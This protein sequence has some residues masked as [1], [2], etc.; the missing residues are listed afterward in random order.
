MKGTQRMRWLLLAL[1]LAAP[2]QAQIEKLGL[3]VEGMT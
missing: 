2:A 1:A 3:R